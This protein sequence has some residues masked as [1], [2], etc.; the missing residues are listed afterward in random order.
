MARIGHLIESARFG[1]AAMSHVLRDRPTLLS[2]RL[3]S[4][5]LS[6]DRF[7]PTGPNRRQVTVTGTQDLAR[8]GYAA[9]ASSDRRNDTKHPRVSYYAVGNDSPVRRLRRS[10]VRP[11]I[12][13]R[14]SQDDHFSCVTGAGFVG[15]LTT[16]FQFGL[17]N[18]EPNAWGQLKRI[19]VLN[20]QYTARFR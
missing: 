17:G 7:R 20:V 4:A 13:R 15:F 2:V 10:V 1:I 3:S 19:S 9:V 14:V 5:L 16:S 18:G 6:D 11:V 8:K 12:R